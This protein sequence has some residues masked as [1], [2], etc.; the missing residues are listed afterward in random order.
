MA[1]FLKAKFLSEALK[2]K[3]NPRHA[4]DQF[5]GG[6]RYDPYIYAQARLTFPEYNKRF[7]LPANKEFTENFARDLTNPTRN[8]ALLK[9]ISP[10]TLTPEMEAA[11]SQFEIGAHMEQQ[12][13]AQATGQPTAQPF[14][15]VTPPTPTFLRPA[16]PVAIK[17]E[18]PTETS[19]TPTQATPTTEA[20][21]TTPPQPQPKASRP[22]FQTPRIPS[23]FMNS[24]RGLGG[25]IGVFFQKNVGKYLTG[26]RAMNFLGK[27]G[28]VGINTLSGITSFG[29]GGGG[30]FSS[31]GGSRITGARGGGFFG[32]IGGIGRGGVGGGS[33]I[34]KAKGRGGLVFAGS[35]IGFMFLTGALAIM[36]T[37]PT[38][39]AAPLPPSSGSPGLDY[40]IPFRSTS[41]TVNNPEGIK[42]QIKNNWPN[43]QLQNWDIIVPQS[44]ANGWN[45]TFVLA[46]WIEES[47]AQGKTPYDD[48]LGCAP[49]PNKPNYDINISL[50]CLFRSFPANEYANDKFADFMCMYSESK[51]A[52]CVF[53][54]NPNFPKNIKYW[55]SQ[56]VP[57]GP[58]AL[59]SISVTE[60][61]KNNFN[62]DISALPSSYQQWAYEI[63]STSAKADIAPKFRGLINKSLTK[64]V[65]TPGDEGS[66]TSG[67]TVYI[68]PGYDVNFFKQILIHELG[69]RIKG[70]AG[71]T[72]PTCNNQT[73]EQIE[74]EGYLTYYAEHATPAQVRTPACGDNDQITRSD[75]D[76]GESVSYYINNKMGELNYGSDCSTYN[77]VNPYTRG[78]RPAHKAYIQCLLGP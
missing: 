43:A 49:D 44:I 15:L 19:A 30:I 38:G 12:S 33:L 53:Q 41:V 1:Q 76:F 14:S 37:T 77:S 31:L 66:H 68:R 7:P 24:A 16:P 69:H 18:Q 72:S 51:K 13:I 36:G 28:N 50:G 40:S 2:W 45:P 9:I 22:S 3:A 61:I 17:A 63:L 56:L 70:T 6:L 32:R 73:I 27:A 29:G 57:S 20:P 10:E 59:T 65:L 78:D 60:Q 5:F 64:V 26:D 74:S 34:G 52:P 58:G 48:P 39:E 11:N 62:I 67:D 71:T 21:P 42:T 75:E 54:T 35:I 4:T 23:T 55:Y 25:N 47:G 46:L 8:Q